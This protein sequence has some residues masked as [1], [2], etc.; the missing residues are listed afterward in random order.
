MTGINTSSLAP[1]DVAL[2]SVHHPPMTER[3]NCAAGQ[4]LRLIRRQLV[5]GSANGQFEERHFEA[6]SFVCRTDPGSTHIGGDD[7]YFLV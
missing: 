4:R 2:A 6:L 7:D 5:A 1:S 3:G